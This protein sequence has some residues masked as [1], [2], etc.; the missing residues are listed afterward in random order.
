M[1]KLIILA[2]ALT[3]WAGGFEAQAKPGGPPSWS[4]DPAHCSV[5]FAVKHIF[6]KIP[7]RFDRFSGTILFDPE[8]LAGSRFDITVETASV[9]TFVAKRDEH[10]RS[11]EFFDVAG[12]PTMR[13]VSNNITHQGGENYLV[14]GEL[15]IKN[16]TRKVALPVKYLGT[17]DN[18]MVQGGKVAGFEAAFSVDLLE[19]GVGDGRFQRMGAMGPTAEATVFFEVIR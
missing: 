6:V 19:Y 4:I 16:A 17:K 10:L 5:N 2:C 13:F 9:N 8:N 14:E 15:T 12:F 11:P 1:K 18:P 3:F 7:G